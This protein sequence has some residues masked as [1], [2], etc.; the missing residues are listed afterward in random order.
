MS[1]A[2]SATCAIKDPKL[3]FSAF[4]DTTE[5]NVCHAKF[6]IIEIFH[7]KHK[8]LNEWITILLAPQKTKLNMCQY[9]EATFGGLIESDNNQSC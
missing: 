7:F 8:N 6:E 2:S 4:S 1:Y 3:H 5:E 9:I